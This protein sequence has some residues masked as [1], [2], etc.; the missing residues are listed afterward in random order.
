MTAHPGTT[1]DVIE[2]SLD[3]YGYP[4]IVSDTAGLRVTDNEV[5]SIG[6]ERA[7]AR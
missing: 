3:F 2:L 4:L 7:K 1:R 6:V 5:E